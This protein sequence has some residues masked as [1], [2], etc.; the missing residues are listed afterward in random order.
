MAN[1]A[2]AQAA[3]TKKV[4]LSFIQKSHDGSRFI[5]RGDDQ[6]KAEASRLLGVTL[7]TA[8]LSSHTQGDISALWLGPDEV[9]LIAHSGADLSA[10]LKNMSA[11]HSLVDVSHRQFAFTI[12]HPKAA[13]FLES[14][15]PLDL[16]LKTFPVGMCTRTQYE[17]TEIVLW[18]HREDCFQVEVWRSFGEYLEGL[19]A[20]SAAEL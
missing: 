14:G 12:T 1:H 18:R 10:I 15:C 6:A 4:D 11:V 13:W 19:W 7:P 16:S 2:A 3:P 9:L 20:Q 5:F 8:A 17:K